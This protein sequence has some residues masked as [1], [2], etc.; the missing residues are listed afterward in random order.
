MADRGRVG[1][2]KISSHSVRM[3]AIR[4]MQSHHATR[5]S[6]IRGRKKGSRDDTLDNTVPRSSLLTHLQYNL[7]RAEIMRVRE[8]EV[9]TNA[10]HHD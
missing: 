8:N 9:P 4:R 2:G 3:N 6:A 7:K 5:L 10:R 1:L